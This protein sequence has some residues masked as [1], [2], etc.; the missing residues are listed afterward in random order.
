MKIFILLLVFFLSFDIESKAQESSLIQSIDN[1]YRSPLNKKRDVFRNPKETL[2]FFELHTNK[3]V[4]EIAPGRGWYTEILSNYMNKTDN[5]YVTNYTD[6]PREIISKI[7]KDFHNHFESNKEKF[8]SYK[9]V[10]FEKNL[11]FDNFKNNYFDLVLTFRNTHNWLDAKSAERVYESINKIM[12]IGG[13]L[14]VVQHRADEDANFNYKLGYVKESF[15]IKLIESKGF[16]LAKKSEI[17]SNPRD[18]KNYPD[19][20]WTLPPRL[21]KKELNKDKYLSIGES[22]RM[23][24]KFIKIKKL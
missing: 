19:G 18:E 4:L 10:K 16:K 23:T 20:V 22:D 12:K 5:F 8:G 9:V 15:L 2:D 13:I 6:P 21:V 7:Q 1:Q 3:K 17:N 14:G 24:L 11:V